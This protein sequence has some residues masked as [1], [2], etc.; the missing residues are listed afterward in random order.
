MKGT[1]RTHQLQNQPSRELP[2]FHA[3]GLGSEELQVLGRQGPLPLTLRKYRALGRSLKRKGP[4]P[5]RAQSFPMS[6]AYLFLDLR[7]PRPCRRPIA[8]AEAFA[9]SAIPPLDETRSQ[10]IAPAV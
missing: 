6:V 10:V 7:L 1:L 4:S 2:C 5:F 9:A 8:L 3:P